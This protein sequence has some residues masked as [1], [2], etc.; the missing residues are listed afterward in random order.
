[1]NIFLKFP[2]LVINDHGKHFDLL[3]WRLDDSASSNITQL[4][5]LINKIE[6]EL[7]LHPAEFNLTKNGIKLTTLNDG[8]CVLI[9]PVVL[10]GK[11]G[12]GSLLR[13]FGKQ[14]TLSTN[15]DACRDLTGRRMKHVNN[16]KRLKEFMTKQAEMAREKEAKKK[17]KVERRRRKLEHLESGGPSNHVFLDPSYDKE[18][19]KI[20]QELEDA[21]GRALKNEG[22]KRKKQHEEPK[23]SADENEK[24]TV[25]KE[26][27]SVP[28]SQSKQLPTTSSGSGFIDSKK[29]K[30]FAT[31]KF[32]DWMGVGELEVSS[33]SEDEEKP[34]QTNKSKLLVFF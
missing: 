17:E 13:S 21:L 7:H 30:D 18:R 23:S 19:S 10:G 4:T 2:R 28:V 20:N 5:N 33:S 14:I 34:Q 12:F 1:M 25:E 11:G 3:C 32:K 31:S 9:S 6:Q 27:A 29:T 26:A 22:L 16:E 24:A 8:D 15:K